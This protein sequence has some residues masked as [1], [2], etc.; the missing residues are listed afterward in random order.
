LS[1]ATSSLFQES[2]NAESS[3]ARSVTTPPW[4]QVLFSP[5]DELNAPGIGV[6]AGQGFSAVRVHPR[7][8]VGVL[9]TANELANSTDP[10]R[11]DRFETSTDRC[12]SRC[13][14]V[15]SDSS[16]S[17]YGERHP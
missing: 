1:T 11:P 3:Y 9:S 13:L 8:R 7:P 17:R 10:L 5:G 15:G 14:P 6:L 2:S 16:R 4:V 12:S